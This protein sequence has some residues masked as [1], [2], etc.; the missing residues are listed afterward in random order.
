MPYAVHTHT[1][2]TSLNLYTQDP[3]VLIDWGI[4][5]KDG[6]IFLMDCGVSEGLVLFWWTMVLSCWIVALSWWTV[7][8]SWWTVALSWTVQGGSPRV[9]LEA[10]QAQ[11]AQ[12]LHAV[13]QSQTASIQRKT[14]RSWYPACIVLFLNQCLCM[15]FVCY[16]VIQWVTIWWVKYMKNC[17]KKIVHQLLFVINNC[18]HLPVVIQFLYMCVWPCF[19]WPLAWFRVASNRNTQN[20]IQRK[21]RSGSRKLWL[22]SPTMK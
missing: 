19:S 9:Q 3:H 7:E 14:S 21:R 22:Q 15:D 20:W 13:C 12:P 16:T 18:L 5:L 17:I 4:V 6:V 8:V 1:H 2:N 11:A 10:A